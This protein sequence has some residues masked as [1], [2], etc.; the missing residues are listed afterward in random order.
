MSLT[1]PSIRGV[2]L[3]VDGTLWRGG[4]PVPGLADFFAFLRTQEIGVRIVTNNSLKLPGYYRKKL[5]RFGVTVSDEEILTSATATGRY[6]AQTL[7]PGDSVY[8]IGE[9][10][11]LAAVRE[12]GMMVAPDAGKLVAAVVVG[13]DRCLTYAKLKHAVLLLQRGAR[14]IG[15][16]PDLLIPTAAGLAPE[17]G[18]TLAALTAATG[19]SP[20]IIGKPERWLFD[21]ALAQLDL[22]PAQTLMV[23]DRLDTD[24]YGA[25]QVGMHTALVTTGVDSAATVTS[26]KIQPDLVA[27]HLG[28]LMEMWGRSLDC[29]IGSRIRMEIR[30]G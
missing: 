27:A 28:E 25:Q 19:V 6:L 10:G 18:V 11:L 24:I 20:T 5:A 22:A 30:R 3:D 17:T 29:I 15:A 9:Q 14:L 16:N 7:V 2:L 23:G 26:H 4:E 13:G 1:L 8:V 21:T 12:A